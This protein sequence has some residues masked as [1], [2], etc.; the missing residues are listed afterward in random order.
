MG[1]EDREYKS[2]LRKVSYKAPA[3]KKWCPQCKRMLDTNKFKANSHRAGG[4]RSWCMECE[5]GDVKERSR[6][7]TGYYDRRKKVEVED[8]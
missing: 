2:L 5:R 3:G 4:L 1:K 8:V 6:R 7:R